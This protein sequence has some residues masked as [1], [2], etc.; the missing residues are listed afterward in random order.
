MTGAEFR[1]DRKETDDEGT[2]YVT[3]QA[4][5]EVSPEEETLGT[6]LFEGLTDGEYR[7]VETKAPAGYMPL[8]SAIEFTIEH[9]ELT[10]S[11]TSTLVTY[12]AATENSPATFRVDNKPGTALPSTGGSGTAAYTATGLA[13]MILAGIL[14]AE[15]KR[16]AHK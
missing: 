11:G 4:A 7:I 10:Y 2:K 9:G 16:K 12:E 13:L 6:L 3:V 5:T 14:L 8:A 15:R 1:L